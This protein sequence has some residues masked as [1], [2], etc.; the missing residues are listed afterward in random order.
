MVRCTELV[1]QHDLA[2]ATNSIHCLLDC[3]C[4]L[5]QTVLETYIPK[6]FSLLLLY[7]LANHLL[8]STQVPCCESCLQ[9]VAGALYAS[10]FS[11]LTCTRRLDGP[12]CKEC[13]HLFKHLLSCFVA[14]ETLKPLQTTHRVAGA[15][16]LYISQ[17]HCKKLYMNLFELNCSAVSIRHHWLML[18]AVHAGLLLASVLC[19]G[20]T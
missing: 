20:G 14:W 2:L 4:S 7:V 6:N 3:F 10:R 5:V 11:M 9:E 16:P 17:S 19:S 15:H 8:W 13:H 18:S 12:I 1:F